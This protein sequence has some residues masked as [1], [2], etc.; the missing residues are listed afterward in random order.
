VKKNLR[1]KYA[2]HSAFLKAKTTSLKLLRSN[3]AF[4]EREGCVDECPKAAREPAVPAAARTVPLEQLTVPVRWDAHPRDT[5][6][7]QAHT[8]AGARARPHTREMGGARDATRGTESARPTSPPLASCCNSASAL[9]A[10]CKHAPYAVTRPS[11]RTR[12]GR[13]LRA[14]W[15]RRGAAPPP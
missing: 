1:Q 8:H 10:P 4:S 2:S 11:E 5:H 12:R 7:T 3:R 9:F 14:S 13:S 15:R 6:H